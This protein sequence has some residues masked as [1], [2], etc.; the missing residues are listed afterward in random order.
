MQSLCFSFPF[1]K[2]GQIC[3]F[4]KLPFCSSPMFV[5][6][7]YKSQYQPLLNFDSAQLFV[8]IK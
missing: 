8:S 6:F 2:P 1:Q 7:T 3:E 5:L 4:S